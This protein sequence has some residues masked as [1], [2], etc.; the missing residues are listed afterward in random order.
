MNRVAILIVLSLL[1]APSVDGGAWAQSAAGV[2]RNSGLP[3]PRFVSLRSSET[4]LRTGPGVRY[5]IDWV[6]RR[7]G[8]PM[9]VIGE[10][11]FWRQ[12]RD[13]EG[14]EG[15]IHRSLLSG[16]RSVVV[17]LDLA[18]M[19]A[20]P[21]DTAGAVARVQ[22]GAVLNLESCRPGWC[23]VRGVRLTGWMRRGALFG[24][25]PDERLD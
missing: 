1:L 3:I 18:V 17:T 12:V 10:Y 19:R 15:W 22:S 20:S 13:S 25:L 7:K 23:R 8:L 5:P 14:I 6:Y 24:I 11:E 2:G 4:N 9:L 16:Q 21:K